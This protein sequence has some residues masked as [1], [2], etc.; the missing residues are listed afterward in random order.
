[1]QS[2]NLFVPLT[3]ILYV[4]LSFLLF[5]FVL[6][7]SVL[8]CEGTGDLP[9]IMEFSD[10]HL[11]EGLKAAKEALANQSGVYCIQNT[12]TES[13][14]IGSSTNM[15][16]RLVSHLVYNATNLHLQS[17]IAKHGLAAFTF[18]V[19]ELCVPKDLLSRE[20]HWLDWLFSLPSHFRYNFSPVA[21]APM[22][23]RTHTDNAKTAIGEANRGC[24]NPNY[25]R[26]AHN[27]LEVCL[28]TLDGVLVQSFSSQSAAAKF[29]GVSQQYI[30]R[31]I[32]RGYTVKGTYR[33]ASRSSPL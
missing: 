33:V 30:F 25:G 19:I 1:M 8:L 16:E 18:I 12:I 13:M 15:G 4:G 31:A 32:Q 10:L 9:T 21:G 14:Y 7:E 20:Q 23:G 26:V 3:A 22:A 6:P 24:N 28:Y 11:T 2:R 5:Y 17:S 29:L 27:A